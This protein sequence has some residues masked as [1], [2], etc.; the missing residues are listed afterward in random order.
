ME[1]CASRVLRSKGGQDLKQVQLGR[2]HAVIAQRRKKND[3][4]SKNNH[5]NKCP[6]AVWKFGGIVPFKTIR[7]K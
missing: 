5:S 4:P 3:N 7:A 6:T 1:E 2:E